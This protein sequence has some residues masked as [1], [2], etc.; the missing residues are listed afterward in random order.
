[1]NEFDYTIE[2]VSGKSNL[3]ADALSRLT[4]SDYMLKGENLELNVPCVLA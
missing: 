1:M 3:V 4:T 2:Y